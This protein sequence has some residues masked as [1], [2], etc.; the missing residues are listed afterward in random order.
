MGGIDRRSFLSAAAGIGIVAA[1]ELRASDVG[2]S[3]LRRPNVVFILADDLGYADLSLFGRREYSTPA[4]DSIGRDGI[5]LP[6]AY[7][8]SP[9]CSPT[10]I[11]L[12]TGRYQYRLRGGLDEPIGSGAENVGLPPDQPSIASLFRQIGYRTVLVGK[13]HMGML[14][15][16]G[17][18]RSGYDRF[19]GIQRG[20]ADYFT[21][22][23]PGE[24]HSDLYEGEALI[25]RHGYLTS[26]LGDR[27]S[28]EIAAA[29]RD[30]IPLFL[31]L[32]Y[33]APHWPWEGPEDE[34]ISSNLRSIL[35]YDG[36]TEQTYARMMEALD[37][38][39]AGVLQSIEAAGVVGD[40]IVVFTSDNGGER[41]SQTWP[42]AGMKGELLEGGIRVPLVVRW[43]NRI[44]AGTQSDQVITSMD[45]LPTLLAAAGG[46]P[47]PS[48]P[49]DGV[50][51]I[52]VLMG[53]AEPRDRTLFWRYKAG[54]QAAVR[55][56]Q[57]KFLRVNGHEYL[58]D[59]SNDRQERANLKDRNPERF[60]EL[61][62]QWDAWNETMLPY[63]SESPSFSSHG[64]G[65]L[66]EHDF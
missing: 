35:H 1:T 15:E 22:R 29:G 14:P 10:R 43:P 55:H 65:Y 52:P 46:S 41:F 9:V 51:L 45:F 17:P 44:A 39:V 60:V 12:A 20:A 56:G 27:A 59:L 54:E 8:N 64:A 4:I 7:A 66:A 63:P 58:F 33:T 31:S 49:P 25:D 13:W 5:V 19:F 2:P 37:R 42:F 40:T 24:E 18:L 23:S 48:A 11:A 53:T 30:G 21:H 16:F 32:H 3:S 28:E 34:Q 26:L 47:D 61:R 36:G 6:E 62:A 57:W 50:N 38:S